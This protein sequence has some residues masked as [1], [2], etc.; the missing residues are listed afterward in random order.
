MKD[1]SFNIEIPKK[2]LT[3]ISIDTGLDL[4]PVINLTLTYDDENK[5]YHFSEINNFIITKNTAL[6]LLD[7]NVFESSLD[8]YLDEEI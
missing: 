6:R 2:V 7:N 4:D 5:S 1:Y 8:L 3:E